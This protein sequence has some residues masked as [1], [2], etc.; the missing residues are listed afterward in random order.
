MS[1]APGWSAVTRDAAVLE[2]AADRSAN[3]ITNAFVAP[4][5]ASKGVGVVLAID[6]VKSA[7]PRPLRRHVAQDVFGK[8]NGRDAV[9]LDHVDFFVQVGRVL[10]S[11]FG[12]VNRPPTPT[13][14]L[15][16][17]ASTGRPPSWILIVSFVNAIELGE[18]GLDGGHLRAEFFDVLGG[19]VDGLRCWTR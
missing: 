6:A 19:L 13:P 7:L 2:F 14:A 18:V 8:V 1:V 4:Y 16:A 15:N 3:D 9:Q 12:P 11:P 17:T 10:A 5:T